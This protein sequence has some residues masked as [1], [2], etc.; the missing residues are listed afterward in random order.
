MSKIRSDRMSRRVLALFAA[1]CFCLAPLASAQEGTNSGDDQKPDETPM[2]RGG[3]DRQFGKKSPEIG[4]HLPDLK[5]YDAEGKE[6]QLGNFKGQY[7]V[8]VFGCLT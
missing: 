4:A 8:L 6:V 2:T 5:A 1:A 7:T 3:V